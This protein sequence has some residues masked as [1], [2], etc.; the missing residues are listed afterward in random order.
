MNFKISSY[1]YLPFD[2]HKTDNWERKTIE[3]LNGALDQY[4]I[5]RI[6]ERKESKETAINFETYIQ[7][8][9]KEVA[10]KI[11]LN[12]FKEYDVDNYCILWA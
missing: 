7:A 12:N 3:I 11:F 8:E 6:E 4:K 2:E 1:L 9:N 5:V 10:E